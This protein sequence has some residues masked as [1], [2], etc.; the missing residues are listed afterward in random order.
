[1][2]KVL[3]LP[4][5]LLKKLPLLKRKRVQR[6]LEVKG[7][8]ACLL[9]ILFFVWKQAIPFVYIATTLTLYKTM[10]VFYL[11]TF[12]H[13]CLTLVLGSMLSQ[14]KNVLCTCSLVMSPT[15]TIFDMKGPQ[16]W[17]YQARQR[18]WVRTAGTDH[19]IFSSFFLPHVS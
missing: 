4:I 6:E 14:Q 8:G 18:L 17:H 1:M 16:N 2:N 15:L 3:L 19:I 12:N 5:Q 9:N 7:A 13:L 11:T 10:H